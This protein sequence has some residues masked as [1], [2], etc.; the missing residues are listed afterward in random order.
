LV[1]SQ[2]DAVTPTILVPSA[3][4]KIRQKIAKLYY[5]RCDVVA[6]K[7]QWSKIVDIAMGHLVR[8]V[9]TNVKRAPIFALKFGSLFGVAFYPLQINMIPLNNLM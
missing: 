2:R 4:G 3:L 5:R 9:D 8:D 7:P 1:L 6:V